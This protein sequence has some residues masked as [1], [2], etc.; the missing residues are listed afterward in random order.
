VE[1]VHGSSH[2]GTVLSEGLLLK[3]PAFIRIIH[4][5]V[6]E[7]VI[8]FLSSHTTLL[9]L[10]ILNACKCGCGHLRSTCGHVSTS[11][12]EHSEQV[13]LGYLSG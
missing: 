10:F 13:M 9:C 2:C 1:H 11:L 4:L 6:G 5:D 3:Y 7:E 12:V 8:N